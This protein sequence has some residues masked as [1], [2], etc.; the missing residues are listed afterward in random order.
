MLAALT[1][2]RPSGTPAASMRYHLGCTVSFLA[3]NVFMRKRGQE[4]RSKTSLSTEFSTGRSEKFAALSRVQTSGLVS[5]G[6]SAT[7]PS[8]GARTATLFFPA[9]GCGSAWTDGR[10]AR[11][12]G[13]A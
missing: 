3:R 2:R 5:A 13:S 8:H 12:D 6:Q 1:A 10:R 4:L 9:D 7:L 11:R